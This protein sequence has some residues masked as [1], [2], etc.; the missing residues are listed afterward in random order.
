MRNTRTTITYEIL[1]TLAEAGKL[2][3]GSVMDHFS[4]RT[5]TRARNEPVKQR[6][7]SPY[8]ARHSFSS[9][10]NRLK[11]E[12]LV[13][14]SGPKKKAIWSITGKGREALTK[15]GPLY[16][17]QRSDNLPPIDGVTRLVTFDVPEKEKPSRHWLRAELLASEFKPLH[18][19]VFIGRRPLHENFITELDRRNLSRYVHIVMLSQRGTLKSRD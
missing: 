14:C 18:K 12:G 5:A 19:S 13:T 6:N 10:L 3:I 17:Y 15:R 9:I 11:R 7:K 4:H 16:K 1:W 2:M 8:P